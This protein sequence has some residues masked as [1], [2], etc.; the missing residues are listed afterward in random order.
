MPGGFP[1]ISPRVPRPETHCPCH[2]RGNP[3]ARGKAEKAEP[4]MATNECCFCKRGADRVTHLIQGPDLF[5]CDIC[6]DAC[7]DTLAVK[8]HGWRERQIDYLMRL[9]QRTLAEEN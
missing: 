8:D 5:I 2:G 6:V 9:R 4:S 3:A 1:G 7:V